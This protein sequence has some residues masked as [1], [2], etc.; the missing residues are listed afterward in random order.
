MQGSY[1]GARRRRLLTIPALSSVFA[2]AEMAMG[3]RLRGRLYWMWRNGLEYSQSVEF[4]SYA[5]E[6]VTGHGVN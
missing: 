2:F 5:G 3:G 6:L 4:G 1:S